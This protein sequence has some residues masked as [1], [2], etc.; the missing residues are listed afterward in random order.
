MT[1]YNP[2]YAC[3]SKSNYAK[4]GKKDIHLVL[5]ESY[6]DKGKVVKDSK[7]LL[8]ESNFP[9]SLYE[10]INLPCRKCVGCRSDN[11]KMWSIR[12]FHELTCHKDNC[13]ITLT[14]NNESKYVQDDPLCLHS[15]RY[16]HFQNFMKRLRKEFPSV[17]IGYIVSGEYGV[18]D[19]RAHWH[20]ILFG[21]NFPDREE[22]Y[23]HK[24]FPHYKSL[25]LERLWS[26]YDRDTDTYFPIGY[27]DLCDV[28]YE[29]CSYV[30]QY[31]MKKL[32]NLKSNPI[33]GYDEDGEPIKLEDKAPPIIRSSKNP[34]I[35]LNWYN[36]FG[37]NAVE[38][39]F[40]VNPKHQR[41]RV[42]T[43][44]YYYSKFEQFHP[45]RFKVLKDERTEKMKKYY[46]KFPLNL[47][48]LKSWEE[49]HLY[50]LISCTKKMLT[51]IKM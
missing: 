10:Y 38:K 48:L 24:G 12:A 28:D 51:N 37:E 34:A 20:A 17:K 5:R 26:I 29:C 9:H 15:L 1:C 3:Y 40:C 30:S 44:A 4:T 49:S 13:F 19:G 43:P 33:V 14:Y 45:E 41:G 50:K 7:W 39:G 27:V 42:S 32:D 16:K 2:I 11:A 36:K 23:R 31:V 6:D 47:N 18:K 46:K 25:I 8:N 35:G 21:F 22:I